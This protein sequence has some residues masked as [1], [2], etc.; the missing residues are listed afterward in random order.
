MNTTKNKS[1]FFAIIAAL[2]ILVIGTTAFAQNITI[3][4]DGRVIEERED[5][6][7]TCSVTTVNRTVSIRGIFNKDRGKDVLLNTTLAAGERGISVIYRGGRKTG[8]GNPLG[9]RF[10]TPGIRP[11]SNIMMRVTLTSNRQSFDP[12]TPWHPANMVNTNGLNFARIDRAGRTWQTY[13]NVRDAKTGPLLRTGNSTWICKVDEPS[14]CLAPNSESWNYV[15]WEP[16][17]EQGIKRCQ[18]I[19]IIETP[20]SV[21]GALAMDTP[22]S[23]ADTDPWSLFGIDFNSL[24]YE[25]DP[26]AWFLNSGNRPI[27]RHSWLEWRQVHL[28]AKSTGRSPFWIEDPTSGNLMSIGDDR[29]GTLIAGIYRR[30]SN[31]SFPDE[32]LAAQMNAGLDGISRPYLLSL[33][34]TNEQIDVVYFRSTDAAG[35]PGE[36]IVTGATTLSGVMSIYRDFIRVGWQDP[37]NWRDLQQIQIFSKFYRH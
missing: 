10:V 26:N 28:R 9:E 29:V 3:L 22:H 34:Q 27:N 25:A 37:N 21:D 20:Q 13:L 2:T 12:T 6:Y 32:L 5:P 23:Q 15:K 35:K 14:L 24:E 16:M 30:L 33:Q 8:P 17:D 11:T 36:N 7:P 19:I 1:Y 31:P 4:P 18:F